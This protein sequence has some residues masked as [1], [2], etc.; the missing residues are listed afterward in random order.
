MSQKPSA[1]IM[2][3]E[4]RDPNTLSQHLQVLLLNKI[5]LVNLNSLILKFV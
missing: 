5:Y 1:V 3:L 2:D 4:D